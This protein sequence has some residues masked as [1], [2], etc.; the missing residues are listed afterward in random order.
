[1]TNSDETK[2]ELG[3]VSAD[4]IPSVAEEAVTAVVEE[5]PVDLDALFDALNIAAS[6]HLDEIQFETVPG[7]KNGVLTVPNT[8]LN[9]DN[10]TSGMD[11]VVSAVDDA[12]L[13]E[14][15]PSDES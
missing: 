14:T 3:K 10:L 4:A 9:A 6:D 1:M 2:N 13:K 5:E 12:V 11:S 8:A 7:E 15:F